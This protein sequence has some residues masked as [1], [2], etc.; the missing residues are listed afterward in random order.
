MADNVLSSR[1]TIRPYR[2]RTGSPR[3]VTPDASTCANAAALI[4]VGQVVQFDATSSAAHRVVQASTGTSPNLS[5]N[6]VGVAAQ[7]DTSDGSTLGLGEGKRQL[8]I[9]AA[10]PTTEFLFP[11]N[12]AGT[13]STLVNT[14]LAL[15]WDSTLGIHYAVAN[16]TA[17]DQRIL[18]TEVPSHMLGD[19]NGFVVGRFFSTAVAPA[20]A[21]R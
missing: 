6:I 10:D 11:T 18:V 2:T 9:W 21:A 5:T 3:I 16:S 13:A 8:S 19:T 17:G 1:T 14:G 12:I 7:A 15:K 4:K 20:I